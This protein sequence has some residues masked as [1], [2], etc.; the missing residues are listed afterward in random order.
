MSDHS[1]TKRILICFERPT[2]H[3]HFAVAKHVKYDGKTV[4]KTHKSLCSDIMN[5]FVHPR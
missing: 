2:F 5:I 4:E 1:K 3:I